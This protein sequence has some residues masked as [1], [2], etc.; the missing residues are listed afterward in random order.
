MTLTSRLAI[1]MILLVTVAVGWL[2]YRSSWAVS[3]I[4]VLTSV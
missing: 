3:M 1:A 4:G 2:S